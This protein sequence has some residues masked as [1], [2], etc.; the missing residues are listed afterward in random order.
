MSSGKKVNASPTKEFFVEMLIRDIFLKEAIIEL[1]DNSIDGAR[2]TEQNKESSKIF[3]NLNK[4]FF[5]IVDNCGG[6][7]LDV[8]REK[9]FR[10]GKIKNKEDET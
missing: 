5:E 1:V 10:F 4:D 2:R 6:I 8:A 3:V 7:P 9:A